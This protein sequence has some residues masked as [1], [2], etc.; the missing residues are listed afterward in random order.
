MRFRDKNELIEHIRSHSPRRAIVRAIDHAATVTLYGGF[1]QVPPSKYGGWVLTVQSQWGMLWHVAILTGPEQL[2]GHVMVIN[3][4]PW[5]KWR[6]DDAKSEVAIGE[7][8]AFCVKQKERML[9]E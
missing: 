4:I 1:T 9:D 7:V 3:E 2:E 6:G 8:P 5:D